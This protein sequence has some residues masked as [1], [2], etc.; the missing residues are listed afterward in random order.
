MLSRLRSSCFRRSTLGTLSVSDSAYSQVSSALLRLFRALS[1]M[2]VFS[3]MKLCSTVTSGCSLCE[4]QL[5][6]QL[7]H[8]AE[9]SV[10]HSTGVVTILFGIVSF[11][12][13]PKSPSTAWF[14]TEEEAAHCVRRS[15]SFK[16]SF[17]VT[18]CADWLTV[19]VDIADFVDAEGEG[20][21]QHH[22]VTRRDWKD[23][24]D[25]R[26]IL[27][28][29]CNVSRLSFGRSSFSLSSRSALRLLSALSVPSHL[30]L[31][32]AWAIQASM[33]TL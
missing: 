9:C 30:W 32:R 5:F 24:L 16:S 1:H 33:P 25:L 22:A 31:S 4:F 19:Q 12:I 21:M 8:F 14:F 6:R 10:Y 18:S 13:L 20:T 23:A 26:K 27:T 7:I 3:S 29:V 15:K 28:I 17:G 11:F 2:D